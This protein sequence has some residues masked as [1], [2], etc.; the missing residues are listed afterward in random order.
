MT[1]R[2]L[3][4]VSILIATTPL[5]GG[6]KGGCGNSAINS[7]SAAPDVS[8]DWAIA[9]DDTLGVEVTIGGAVYAQEI[10]V[11][12]GSFTIDHE[13]RPITFDLDCARPEVVCPSEQWPA[14]VS[15]V[16]RNATF[17]HR[18]WVTI[19]RQECDGPTVAADPAECGPDTNN[20]DCEDVCMG[21]VRT[22]ERET[23]GVI[24]EPGDHFDLLLGAGVATNGINCVLL[25]VSSAN[26]DLTTTG[27]ADMGDWR[28]E[29]MDNGQVVVAYSGGCLWAGDPDMDMELEAIVVGAS[30]KFTTGFTGTRVE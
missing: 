14:M 7:R 24:N 1:A 8:G 5:L 4:L 25:G 6:A 2:R 15:A 19:P 23:F 16:Q 12:G 18:M 22:V 20:P 3:L 27:T 29:S 9:Y 28:A 21:E 11:A 30:V 17:P 13:G 10:G 26:A